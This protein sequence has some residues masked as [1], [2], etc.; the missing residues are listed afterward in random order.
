VDSIYTTINFDTTFAFTSEKSKQRIFL[1]TIEL[2]LFIFEKQCNDPDAINPNFYTNI[3]K[4]KLDLFCVKIDGKKY[5]YKFLLKI[6]VDSKLLEINDKYLNGSFS[7]SYRILYN[8]TSNNN[9]T[10]IEIDMKNVF[11]NTK[12]KAY[13]INK[14]PQYSHLIEDCYRTRINLNEFVDFLYKNEGMKL[15]S[16]IENG[17]F[18]ERYLDSFRIMDY[19]MRALKVNL[20]NIWFGN[21]EQNRFYNSI[22]SL[23]SI[24]TPFILLNDKNVVSIDIPNCQPLLLASLINNDKYKY[25]VENGLLYENIV[26]EIGLE[27]NKENRNI[28]KLNIMIRFFD[29]KKILSGRIFEAFNKLYPNFI[30]QLNNLKDTAKIAHL[31]HKLETIIMVDGVGSL[32]MAKLL[33]HDEVLI[34]EENKDKV[35]RYIENKIRDEFKLNIK[36]N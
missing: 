15:K 22:A 30:N 8:F 28:I 5:G 1:K 29:S 33:K 25:D 13:W 36:L 31:T 4:K 23:P 20:K 32:N 12:D 21:S 3:H 16:T 34:Y 14:Y 2:W 17:C 10:E 26:N 18:K 19:I 7:K 35:I 27:Y 24:V 9:T 11:E 6:L